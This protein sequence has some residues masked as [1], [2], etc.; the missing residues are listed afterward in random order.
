M[1]LAEL[2][3]LVHGAI[4]RDHLR[5]QGVLLRQPTLCIEEGDYSKDM[6]SAVF[7]CA[8]SWVRKPSFDV[9][10]KDNKNVF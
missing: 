9:S 10:Q 1:G 5:V 2:P 4:K 7:G 8:G 6:V 3:F